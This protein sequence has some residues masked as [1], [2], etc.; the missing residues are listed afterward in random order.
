MF[1]S[2][3]KCFREA[4]FLTYRLPQA[5]SAVGAHGAG[6]CMGARMAPKILHERRAWRDG[7]HGASVACFL[8][9]RIGHTRKDIQ[10]RMPLRRT[11]N[12]GQ[13]IQDFENS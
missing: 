3:S 2:V 9:E 8:G 7:A 10:D 12:I 1:L 5:P 13:D 11:Y 4:S 6:V